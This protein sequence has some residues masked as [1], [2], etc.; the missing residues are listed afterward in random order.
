MEIKYTK[1]DATS[2]VSI[3]NK[4]I[5]H[6]CND[7]GGW[8]KGFVTAISAK[9]K[10]PELAYRKWYQSKQNF[11]LGEVQLVKVE[12]DIW[13]GNLIAQKDIKKAK[14]GTPPIRYDAID[15]ALE[16]IASEAIKLNASIHMPRI[17]CGL[18]GGKWGKVEPIIVNKLISKSIA[19]VVYDF[20]IG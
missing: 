14:D 1:G 13:V 3:G 11:E 20:E 4:I 6:V 17:G 5:V 10:S 16:T 18:A 9:W 15:K 7:V 8:G 2:P 12:E 19:V